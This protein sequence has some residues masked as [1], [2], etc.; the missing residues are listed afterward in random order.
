MSYTHFLIEQPGQPQ[1]QPRRSA[2]ASSLLWPYARVLFLLLLSFVSCTQ[3]SFDTEL[4]TD[5]SLVVRFLAGQEDIETCERSIREMARRLPVGMM[6]VRTNLSVSLCLFS[7][8][9][10]L[11]R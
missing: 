9:L 1:P 5:K 11:L 2:L 3:Q 7:A 6:G 10:H 8:L 4:N